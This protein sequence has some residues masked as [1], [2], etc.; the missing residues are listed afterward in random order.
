MA[1]SNPWGVFFKSIAIILF[2]AGMIGGG[3][4]FVTGSIASGIVSFVMVI[5]AQFA[6]NSIVSTLADRRNKEAEFLAQQVLREAS[7]LKLPYNLNCAYCNAL[8]RIGIS[9]VAENSFSCS[10]C[11][12]PNKVYIQFSTVRVTTPLTQKDTPIIDVEEDAGV[13]QSTINKP[14]VMNEK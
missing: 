7:E 9:F 14:I 2:V 11:N 8:N 4:G 10:Q 6:G 3:I 5:I 1:Q 13:T 12:Q